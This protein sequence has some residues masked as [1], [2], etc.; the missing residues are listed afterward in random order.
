MS[1]LSLL[2]MNNSGSMLAMSNI[3]SSTTKNQN[4]ENDKT[5]WLLHITATLLRL[6]LFQ[7]MTQQK[8]TMSNG[9]K[10]LPFWTNKAE[11]TKL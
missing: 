5:V 11:Q 3:H 2:Y 1:F 8:K 6:S 9:V 7:Q 4:K 10:S